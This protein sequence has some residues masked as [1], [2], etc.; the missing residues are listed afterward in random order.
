MTEKIKYTLVVVLTA[1]VLLGFSLIRLLR[2][3]AAYS[4]SER[5]SLA[6][7]PEASAELLLSGRYMT[8]FE[9][10]AQDQFP[11][12]DVF[13]GWKAVSALYA[14]GKKDNN[15][16]YIIDGNISK[17]EYPLN[18]SMIANAAERFQNIYDRYLSGTDCRVFLSVIPDKNAFLAPSG[19]YLSMDYTYF[20]QEICRQMEYAAYIDLFPELSLENYYLTDQHWRQETLLPAAEILAEGMG[21]E[22]TDTF[23]VQ[24]LEAPFYGAYCG[25][26]ALPVKPDALY[27]LTSD[28]LESCMVTSYNT[29]EPLPGRI[30]DM[31]RA[32]G[33]DPYEMFLMGAD[34]LLVIENPN[35][36]ADR[37]LVIF[38]DSFGSS[39]APLLASGYNK[40]TLV[41]LRYIRSGILDRFI[42]FGEQDVLFLYSTLILNHSSSLR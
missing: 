24:K 26:I 20:V 31:D 15:G 28:V 3:P 12:R 9:E 35:A 32:Y 34:A 38:R 11:M 17:L 30:Y 18:E 2:E 40:I 14:F 22:L 4:D 42:D 36:A 16:L 10:Y 1:M 19:G 33:R 25:Q 23:T 6:Q 5:R 29:G 8:D 41:D 13:R 27:Y 21:V 37:E 7:R 39:L